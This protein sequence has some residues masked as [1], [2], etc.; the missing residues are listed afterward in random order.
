MILIIDTFILKSSIRF[1][2]QNSKFLT[3]RAKGQSEKY[4]RSH[5]MLE[6]PEQAPISWNRV[7]QKGVG[8]VKVR[9]LL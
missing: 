7:E 6:H 8:I 3:K 5:Y 4:S 2:I 9:L 1:M